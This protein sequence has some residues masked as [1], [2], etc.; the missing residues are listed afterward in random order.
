MLLK[1]RDGAQPLARLRLTNRRGRPLGAALRG[2][3]ARR[4]GPLIGLNFEALQ[5][6]GDE[7]ADRL[8]V[9]AALLDDH[10]RQPERAERA[11]GFGVAV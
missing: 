7:L 8:E 5:E 2:L 10:R 11:A 1:H 3:S 9:V 6:R 4:A